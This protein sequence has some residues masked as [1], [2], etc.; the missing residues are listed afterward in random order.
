MAPTCTSHKPSCTN[1]WRAPGKRRQIVTARP[2]TTGMSHEHGPVRMPR[3]GHAQWRRADWQTIDDVRF[4]ESAQLRPTRA[5]RLLPLGLSDLFDSE[6]EL[7]P[8]KH[9]ECRAVR[10]AHTSGDF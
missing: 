1:C 2:H 9:A 10:V 6:V 4:P 8:E 3:S 5:D 7:P